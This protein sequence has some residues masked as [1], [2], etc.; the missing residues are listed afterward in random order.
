[1]ATMQLIELA[2]PPE[3]GFA[4]AKKAAD[5]AAAAA[6]GECTCMAFFDRQAGRESPAHASECH[7]DCEV[8]GYEEYAVHRG[9]TLKVV[10]NRGDYVFLYR[11]LGEFAGL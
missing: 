2:L 8:P 7:G 3:A 1:M 11:P 4:D 10:V 9:A 5:A 6:L